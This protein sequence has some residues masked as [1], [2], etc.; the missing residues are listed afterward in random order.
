[1][2]SQDKDTLVVLS[3]I[4]LIYSVIIGAGAA[5]AYYSKR[6]K[7]SLIAGGSV[8]LALIITTL[9][10]LAIP[11]SLEAWGALVILTAFVLILA[12]GR[13]WYYPDEDGRK[14]FMPM[15]AVAVLSLLVVIIELI[16]LIVIST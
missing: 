5:Y 13:Y 11:K 1:M 14:K 12:A 15:G 3:V 2:S 4:V 9:V 7:P 6:S 8:S 10:T 16:A